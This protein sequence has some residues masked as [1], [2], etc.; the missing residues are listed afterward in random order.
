MLLT[1]AA[2][3]NVRLCSYFSCNLSGVTCT[4]CSWPCQA[5][6]MIY[7]VM[8]VHLPCII[9]CVTCIHNHVLHGYA[10]KNIYRCASCCARYLL[11]VSKPSSVHHRLLVLPHISHCAFHLGGCQMHLSYQHHLFATQVRD[12]ACLATAS[13]ALAYPEE[14]RP[15]LE[16][17]FPLWKR[18][19]DDNVWSVR[20]H[21]AMALADVVRAYQQPALDIVVPCLR[22]ICSTT[23][24]VLGSIAF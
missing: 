23:I 16:V 9:T 4:A 14:C 10:L 7:H 18:Q 15:W 8:H 19:L 6:F 5:H 3:E 2:V 20:A 12:G 21:A 13:C 11:G 24:A 17:L 1:A 22:C